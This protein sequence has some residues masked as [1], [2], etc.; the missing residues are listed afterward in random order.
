MNLGDAVVRMQ[1]P[2]AD[3]ALDLAERLR[4]RHAVRTHVCADEDEPPRMKLH[5][6]QRALRYRNRQRRRAPVQDRILS[7]LRGRSL[8]RAQVAEALGLLP[9]TISV[10]IY[11]MWCK[12]LV[13]KTSTAQPHTYTA[14]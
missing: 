4:A 1:A 5:P 9:S 3:G 13:L 6:A 8:T 11:T 2:L 10:R 12:G 7:I 14:A